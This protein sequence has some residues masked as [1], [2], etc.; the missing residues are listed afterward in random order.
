[1]AP[2]MDAALSRP[3]GSAD[4]GWIRKT[5][6]VRWELTH[7]FGSSPLIHP[8]PAA[9]NLTVLTGVLLLA[10]SCASPTPSHATGRG[11]EGREPASAKVE[12]A[13]NLFPKSLQSNPELD[14]T[15]YTE[16]TEFGRQLTPPTPEKPVY[17]VAQPKGYSQLGLSVAGEKPPSLAQIDYLVRKALLKN[18]YRSVRSEQDRP[19]I[20]IE[21]RWGTFNAFGPELSEDFRNFADSDVL[22]RARL[23]GGPKL[24]SRLARSME[25][26]ETFVDR[27]DRMEFFKEQAY[28]SI[29]FVVVQAFD[30]DALMRGQKRLLWRTNMT[31]NSGGVSI[32]ETLPPLIAG[33]A[34]FLGKETAEPEI[35]SA[36][37]WRKEKIEIGPATVIGYHDDQAPASDESTEKTEKTRTHR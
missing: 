9:R 7:P 32:K 23:V 28:N 33:A 3:N 29:Y 22:D 5:G 21:Y 26:G 31:V 19:S 12:L 17:Y 11:G 20:S 34:P 1:M 25:W 14:M 6:G 4:R 2:R 8:M 13:F 24:V 30:Y 16:L 15:V 18:G 35:T 37:L 36:K 10:G 27:E